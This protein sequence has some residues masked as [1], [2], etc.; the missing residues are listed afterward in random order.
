MELN[1]HRRFMWT[2]GPIESTN[3]QLQTFQPVHSGQVLKDKE[4][5][6]FADEAFFP[7]PTPSPALNVRA[8]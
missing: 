7:I 5:R 8:A 6:N 3:R 2:R 4:K 1:Q